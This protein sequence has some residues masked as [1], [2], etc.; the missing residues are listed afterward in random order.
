MD[1][2]GHPCHCQEDGLE[3]L[4]YTIPLPQVKGKIGGIEGVGVVFFIQTGSE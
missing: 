4:N 2:C 1:L 3:L